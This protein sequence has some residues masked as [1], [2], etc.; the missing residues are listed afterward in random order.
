MNIRI[1]AMSD[2]KLESRT[3]TAIF[4]AIEAFS[5]SAYHSPDHT[6]EFH[7]AS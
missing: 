6:L 3:V 7:P 4:S 1:L 5:V 2:P